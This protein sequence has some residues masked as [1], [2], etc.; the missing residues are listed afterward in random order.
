ML[1]F[2]AVVAFAE[3][4]FARALEAMRDKKVDYRSSLGEGEQAFDPRP[5]MIQD[6]INCM[7]WMQGVI[8]SAYGETPK[9]VAQ[10]LD[11]LRYYGDTISFGT[12]KHYIDRWLALE[13]APLLV[14]QQE[15]CRPNVIG[16]VALDLQRFK[17][18]HGYRE[19]MF[20]EDR[21]QFS[22]DFLTPERMG[23]CLS[24]LPRGS[25]PA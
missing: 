20:V 22:L 10:Y 15:S 19:E 9:E 1:I 6:T 4:D 24:S 2:L 13:P 21:A 17:K 14:V 12:R 18:N 8:A 23:S 25:W 3:P 11:S 5:R 7:T 16:S